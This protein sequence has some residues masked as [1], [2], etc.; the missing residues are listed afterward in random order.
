MVGKHSVDYGKRG[1]SSCPVIELQEN[2]LVCPASASV[3]LKNELANDRAGNSTAH[4][5]CAPMFT[6]VSCQTCASGFTRSG[7]TDC[8]ECWSGALVQLAIFGLVLFGVLVLA[9]F[10]KST[11]DSKGEPSSEFIMMGKMLVTH[12]QVIG[13]QVSPSP[14]TPSERSG[15]TAPVL[16]LTASIFLSCLVQGVGVPVEMAAQPRDL[17]R[18]K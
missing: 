17:L 12:L 4:S 9:Y 1:C 18:A 3:N 14:L 6:G 5:G 10:V 8:V 11:I 16:D 7:E 15:A 2:C 13:M